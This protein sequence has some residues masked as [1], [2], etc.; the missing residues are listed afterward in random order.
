[1]TRKRWFLPDTPDVLGMLSGQTAVTIDGADAF[2]RW[3]GGDSAAAEAVRDARR[4]GDMA[5]ATC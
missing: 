1:M 5:N 2:A 3:A 4:R